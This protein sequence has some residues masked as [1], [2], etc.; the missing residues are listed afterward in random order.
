[1]PA[2]LSRQPSKLVKQ[3]IL[4]RV[5]GLALRTTVAAVRVNSLL[6]LGDLVHSLDKQAVLDIIQTT[7]RC[8]AVDRSPPTLMCTLGVSSSV[9][10]QYGT[11]FAAEHILPLITPLLTAQQLNTQQFAKYMQFVKDILRRI[12]E[13]RGV[14]P[15]DSGGPD[16]KTSRA[17]GHQTG[18]WTKMNGAISV[19]SAAKSSPAWDED[20]GPNTRTAD[21]RTSVAT[22]P[23]PKSNNDKQLNSI[24]NLSHALA[25]SSVSSSQN[26]SFPAIDIEWPPRTSVGVTQ[27]MGDGEK[28]DQNVSTASLDDIDPFADWPPRPGARVN[29]SISSDSLF[30]N[31]VVGVS[32]DKYGPNFNTS[33]Y[34]GKGPSF[35]TSSSTRSLINNQ[36]SW[37]VGN[38]SLAG[39]Q[40]QNQ[41]EPAQSNFGPLS[42][43]GIHNSIGS[44]KQNQRITGLG[45][46]SADDQVM[47]I[48]SIFH[49]VKIER[50]APKLAPPPSAVVGR[51]RGK[52]LG[53]S[54]AT[55]LPR[56]SNPKASTAQPPLLDLL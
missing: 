51:G 4:P 19:S 32:Q 49:P 52:G 36:A 15:T 43:G 42:G 41:A 33:S 8:T 24:S 45:N 23:S 37:A 20:W 34:A 40:V 50:S 21:T 1:M 2:D 6:C 16:T 3:E 48:G 27:Q 10:K 11:E 39:Q 53:T 44:L 56:S 30:S 47:G 28:Q 46:A 9:L 29:A 38:Q 7:Q 31:G 5:H 35:N 17:D 13:K 12:E 26:V 25:V 54:G 18:S 14:P 55:T 22:M